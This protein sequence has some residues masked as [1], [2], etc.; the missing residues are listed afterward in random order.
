MSKETQ[1]LEYEDELLAALQNAREDIK[2][3]K[4]QDEPHTITTPEAKEMLQLSRIRTITLLNKLC[5]DGV[6]SREMIG[7]VNNWGFLTRKPGYKLIR[8]PT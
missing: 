1:M 8:E 5:D 7:R 3:G 4:E 6:L 2:Q